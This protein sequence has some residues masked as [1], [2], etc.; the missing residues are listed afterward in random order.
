MKKILTLTTLLLSMA[1]TA[2][3]QSPKIVVVDMGK[4]FDEYGKAKE[5]LAKY[6]SSVKNADDELK[7]MLDAGNGMLEE[8]K[9]L[10]EKYQNP[11]TADEAKESIQKEI[12]EKTKVIREK[13]RE[14][15]QYRQETTGFL[16]ESRKQLVNLHV[17]EIREVVI[18]VAKKQKA[19][20]VLN[21]NREAAVVFTED[22]F[23]ITEEVLAV[24]NAE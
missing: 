1:L 7:K 5:A 4:L 8:I 9:A 23:E 17:A 21:S 18:E 24:L 20:I 3:A 22:A 19:D 12:A 15:N 13:E 16:Q 14:V 10:Q 11:M 2:F 6:G